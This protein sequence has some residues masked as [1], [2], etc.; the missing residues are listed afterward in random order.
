MA[1]ILRRTLVVQTLASIGSRFTL[2]RRREKRKVK[3]TIVLLMR[4]VAQ[5]GEEEEGEENIIKVSIKLSTL[6]AK[7]NF[8]RERGN[9][10]FREIERK[11]AYFE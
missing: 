4:R 9:S 7:L 2:R 8:R 5:V 11:S 3:N 6:L 1:Q 10:K